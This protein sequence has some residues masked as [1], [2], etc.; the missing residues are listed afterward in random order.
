MEDC[1]VISPK[2]ALM[3]TRLDKAIGK[4]NNSKE[5]LGVNLWFEEDPSDPNIIHASINGHES[6]KLALEWLYMTY[7]EVAYFNC[8]CGHR[9]ARMY[10]VPNGSEFRCRICHKLKYRSSSTNPKSIA[11]MALHNFSRINKIMETRENMSRIFYNGQY[12]KRFNRFL[13]LCNKAGL[14]SMVDDAKNLAEIV[15]TQEILTN[16]VD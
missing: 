8:N 1:F 15:K 4:K 10:L 12:T 3:G 11:G 14:D 13:T 9:V 2:D 5:S 16:A 7:G 6:Q